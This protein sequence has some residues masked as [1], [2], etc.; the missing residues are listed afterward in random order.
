MRGGSRYGNDQARGG[1]Y[2]SVWRMSLAIALLLAGCGGADSRAELRSLRTFWAQHEEG[3]RKTATLEQETVAHTRRWLARGLESEPRSRAASESGRISVAWAAVH[4]GYRW[5][6]Q[7]LA[8]QSYASPAARGERDRLL[9][10]L[11]KSQFR[12]LELEHLAYN[13]DRIGF[14]ETPLGRVPVQIETMRRLM[15]KTE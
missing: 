1:V 2:I 13:A 8:K 4:V 7:E 6:A 14:R 11:R 5:L 12:A 10:H 3:Y 15:A 9:K